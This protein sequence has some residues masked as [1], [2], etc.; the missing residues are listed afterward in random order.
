MQIIINS[1]CIELNF[2]HFKNKIYL[3]IKERT[4]LTFYNN[5]N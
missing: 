4:F 1:G 3:L 5:V 2:K